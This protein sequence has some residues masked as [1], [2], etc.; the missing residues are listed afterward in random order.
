[1]ATIFYFIIQEYDFCNYKE[2]L[3]PKI[4]NF[5]DNRCLYEVDIVLPFLIV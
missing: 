1:M 2:Q 3:Y 5:K 4:R